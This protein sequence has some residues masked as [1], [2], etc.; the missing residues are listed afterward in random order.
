MELHHGHVAA[1][2]R[3]EALVSWRHLRTAAREFGGH[4]LALG[5]L[6]SFLKETQEG[7]VRRRVRV[8]AFLADGDNP[9]Q[10]HA[11]RVMESIE[12]EWLARR[13]VLLAILHIVGLFDRPAS[14][15]CQAAL[16]AEPAIPGLTETIVGADDDKWRRAVSRLR[17]AR[18]LA[19]PRRLSSS[20]HLTPPRLQRSKRLIGHGC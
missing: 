2:P 17:D 20:S 19:P 1:K 10:D 5:L 13:P 9:G 6:A 14:G 4:P 16:R 15:D 7:D 18:L 8:R 11:V 12:K 3:V